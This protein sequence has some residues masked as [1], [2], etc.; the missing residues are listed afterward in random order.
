MKLLKLTGLAALVLAVALTLAAQAAVHA[1]DGYRPIP[2]YDGYT[3]Y[4]G[5]DDGYRPGR[6]HR[7]WYD[8]RYDRDHRRG[9]PPGHLPPPAMRSGHER[10]PPGHMSPPGLRRG[11]Y[12]HHK[13]WEHRGDRYYDHRYDRDHRWH[14]DRDRYHRND[15]DWDVTIHKDRH[16]TDVDIRY[17]KW[18]R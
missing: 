6:Y 2:R 5:D 1:D 18:D 7:D 16:G 4:I 8:D 17:R 9:I 13:S 12:R 15:D 11:H 14:H 3:K 10:V